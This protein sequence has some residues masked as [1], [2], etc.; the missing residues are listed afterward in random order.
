MAGVLGYE[1]VLKVDAKMKEMSVEICLKMKRCKCLFC[2]WKGIL[3][4]EAP[5]LLLLVRHVYLR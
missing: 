5:C 1:F 3:R 2:Y 4:R